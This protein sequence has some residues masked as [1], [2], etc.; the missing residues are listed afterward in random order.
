[1]SE[2][3]ESGIHGSG[4]TVSNLI[5]LI[6]DHQEHPY[7]HRELREIFGLDRQILLS[8]IHHR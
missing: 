8:D 7:T 2:V 1:M 4:I 6:E 3:T 5:S